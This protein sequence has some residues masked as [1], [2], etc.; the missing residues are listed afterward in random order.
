M[1]LNL[2]NGPAFSLLLCGLLINGASAIQ[3]TTPN[4][5]VAANGAYHSSVDGKSDVDSN[6]EIQLV[7][8]S[9]APPTDNCNGACDGRCS[10]CVEQRAATVAVTQPTRHQVRQPCG[11]CGSTGQCNC[12]PVIPTRP[13]QFSHPFHPPIE[14]APGPVKSILGVNEFIDRQN[15]R[16]ATFRHSQMVPWEMFA[17]GEYVGPHRTPHVPEYRL[18]VNDEL[19]FVYFLTRRQSATPYQI[20]VGDSITIT[21]ATDE[22]VNQQELQVLSD[23]MIS[24]PLISQVRAAGKTISDLQD[25][26][27]ELYEKYL[28]DPSILVQVVESDTPLR[29]ILDSVDARGGVGGQLR[30]ATVSP[31]GTVQLPVVGSIPAVGLTLDEIRRE[32]NSRYNLYVNGLEV[33]PV[34]VAPAPRFVYV[35]GQVTT[36]GRFQLLGPTTV[37]QAIALAE[38][39]L[40]GA[41]LRNIVVFRR[42]EAWRLTA[43]RLDLAGA[44]HGRRPLPSD[45]IYLRDSDIVLLPRKPIQRISEAVDLYLTQT[46]YSA[47][48]QELIF[49]DVFADVFSGSGGAG[50]VTP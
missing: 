8:Y 26:L 44:I 33:T 3:D 42:D 21:S 41:N 36:P 28:T 11:G 27:N 12:G 35:V 38:G 25:E 24:L 45:D 10:Q 9:F 50:V 19:E 46:L 23:G 16:E 2:L 47:V 7:Q 20:Y 49:Q 30:Q 1:K 22:G 32:I 6:D 37:L 29:D 48:P 40:Q 4:A 18:R 17:Y 13:R 43:T 31:D 15:G 39:D 5:G 14:Q 34:L